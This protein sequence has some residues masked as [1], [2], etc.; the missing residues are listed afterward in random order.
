[1]LLPVLFVC[2]TVLGRHVGANGFNYNQYP[3]A[4][5]N[6]WTQACR[7]FQAQAFATQA[8]QNQFFTNMFPQVQLPPLPFTD[9]CSQS[10]F[11]AA[12][13]GASAGAFSHGG[14]GGGVT[15]FN[16]RFGG[17]DAGGYGGSGGVQGVSISSS[18][19]GFGQGGT[20]VTHFGNGGASSNYIPHNQ[21]GGGGISTANRFGGGSSGQGVSVSSFGT[22]NGGGYATANRFGGS[23]SG[24]GTTHYVSNNGGSVSSYGPNGGSFASSTRFGGSG[25]GAGSNYGSGGYGGGSYGGGNG[26]AVGASVSSTSL[27]NGGGSVQTSVYKQHY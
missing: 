22:S 3:Q 25:G 27:G 7:S 10:G 11:A 23:G 17:N 26:V 24:G 20:T 19:N 5:V 6:A 12:G 14:A 8:Q 2:V 9:L 13:A 4:Q 21:H 16:N 1:M 18:S 15:S